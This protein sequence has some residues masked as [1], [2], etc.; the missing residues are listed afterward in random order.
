MITR[1][2]SI[3]ISKDYRKRIFTILEHFCLLALALFISFI[4]Y[5]FTYLG[6]VFCLVLQILFSPVT[7]SFIKVIETTTMECSAST[8]TFAISVFHNS[9]S[10]CCS[11]SKAVEFFFQEKHQQKS[12]I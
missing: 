8:L 12:N 1:F 10:E 3:A 5:F 6:S 4:L 11:H 7:R 9:V 2:R